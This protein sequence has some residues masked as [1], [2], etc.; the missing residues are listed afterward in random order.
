MLFLGFGK[1]ME[2]LKSDCF[3]GMIKSLS[4]SETMMNIRSSN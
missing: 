3:V 2:L 1:G 4:Y